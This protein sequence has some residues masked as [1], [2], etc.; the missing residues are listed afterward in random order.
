MSIH[1]KRDGKKALEEMLNRFTNVE[2][3]PKEQAKEK[4]QDATMQSIF[5]NDMPDREEV[6]KYI[7]QLLTPVKEVK[8]GVRQHPTIDPSYVI[9]ALT[10]Y[11]LSKV[12][13]HLIPLDTS[14]RTRVHSA[15]EAMLL[16]SG[17]YISSGSNMSL[18]FSEKIPRLNEQLIADN[19]DLFD[20]IMLLKNAKDETKKFEDYVPIQS[21]KRI[22]ELFECSP[23]H[24]QIKMF[25]KYNIAV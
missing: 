17:T 24:N 18:I 23:E 9:D 8:N 13:Q 6:A 16:E 15:I 20:I 21:L 10:D 19:Q 11:T 12:V 4:V 5:P 1:Q 22:D 3:F 14:D 7:K 2:Y 25:K